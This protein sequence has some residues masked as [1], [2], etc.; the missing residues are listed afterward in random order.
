M[1]VQ[2]IGWR[3]R[4]AP[5]KNDLPISCRILISNYPHRMDKSFLLEQ[6]GSRLRQAVQDAHQA[7]RVAAEDAKSQ[8]ARAVNLARG[9]TMRSLA[10]REALDVL[11][12]FR[13]QP[14]GK[15]EKI[16][17][18]CVVELEDG[19]TGKTLFLAPVGA[20]EELTG[21]GGDGI[22]QVV[23]PQSPF[24]RAI[25]GKKVG[26]VVEVAVAGEW[27]EWRISFAA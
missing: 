7:A 14:L 5:S 17:L 18:G 21:P 19:E 8:A 23:T 3:L 16:G 13:V 1:H 6:L 26:D 9:Q 25:L 12:S 24:G 4:S 2:A 20:G 11:N 27:T 22:F 10:A 15:N